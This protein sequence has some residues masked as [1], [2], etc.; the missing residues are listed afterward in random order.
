MVLLI[1][2]VIPAEAVNP[3]YN[4]VLDA[5]SGKPNKVETLS[6]A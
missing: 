1:I 6:P 4:R 3:G 5:G 2:I